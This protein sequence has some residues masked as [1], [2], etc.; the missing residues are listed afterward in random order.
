MH[1][2][3]RAAVV[4]ILGTGTALRAVILILVTTAAIVALHGGATGALLRATL[5]TRA[6]GVLSERRG[7]QTQACKQNC[8]SN[9]AFL[10]KFLVERFMY[11]ASMAHASCV[12]RLVAK[13]DTLLNP[14]KIVRTGIARRACISRNHATIDPIKTFNEANAMFPLHRNIGQSLIA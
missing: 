8:S 11:V 4:V 6:G 10:H 7:R 13:L 1:R 5:I 14:Y 2:H 12:P 3:G 9:M